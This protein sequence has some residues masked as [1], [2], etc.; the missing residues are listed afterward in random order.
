M[1]TLLSC[2]C[3]LCH[4]PNPPKKNPTLP[5]HPPQAIFD[6]PEAIAVGRR[7]ICAAKAAAA[8]A[9]SSSS[10]AGAGAGALPAACSAAAAA[11]GGPGGLG[12]VQLL[13]Y[14]GGMAA[15]YW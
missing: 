14:Y 9:A 2:H 12:R 8:A 4:L 13:A 1:K 6:I 15:Y 3:N 10:G 5:P 7:A 11:A